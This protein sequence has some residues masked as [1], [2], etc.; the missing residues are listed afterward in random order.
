MIL[1]TILSL[2]CFDVFGITPSFYI[3]RYFGPPLKKKIQT[4]P[5]ESYLLWNR[6]LWMGIALIGA[7]YL[8]GC[9][10][11]QRPVHLFCEAEKRKN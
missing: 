8:L 6:L 2:F 1:K 5:L 9:F 11:F 7:F 10:S 3:T 4:I